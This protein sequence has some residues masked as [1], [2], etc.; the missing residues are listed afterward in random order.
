MNQED[1]HHCRCFS[2][3]E[4]DIDEFRQALK[5]IGFKNTFWQDDHDHE[6]GLVLRIDEY[7]QLHVK[8]DSEGHIEAE[9]EYP[10]DYPIA[11]L[12]QNHSYSAHGQLKEVFKIV[13]I[14]HKSK[15]IPPLSCFRPKIIPAV[16]PTHAK[17][18]VGVVFAVA[19]IG[20]LAYA[21]A[22]S[23]KS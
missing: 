13:Q 2:I 19:L 9:I 16:K 22:K 14:S 17:V 6:F 20:V 3:D 18:I 8:V 10:P 12:N 23:S 1:P 11:H 21:V 5:E 4:L 7:T 15:F